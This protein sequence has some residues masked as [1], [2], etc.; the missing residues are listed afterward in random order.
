MTRRRAAQA[1][2]NASSPGRGRPQP[3][4]NVQALRQ[5]AGQ[6]RRRDEVPLQVAKPKRKSS[7]SIIAA[8]GRPTPRARRPRPSVE[9]GRDGADQGRRPAARSG[10]RA[11][12]WRTGRSRPSGLV[13]PT[14]TTGRRPARRRA[15]APGG[16]GGGV[17]WPRGG[18]VPGGGDDGDAEPAQRPQRRPHHRV[19]L[20]RRRSWQQPSDSDTTSTMSSGAA[21]RSARGPAGLTARSG[22]AGGRTRRPPRRAVPPDGEDAASGQRWWTRPG[23]EPRRRATMSSDP[24]SFPLTTPR[25]STSATPPRSARSAAGAGRVP[26]DHAV[27]PGWMPVPVSSTATTGRRAPSSSSPG[28]RGGRGRARPPGTAAGAGPRV[29]RGGRPPL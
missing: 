23:D 19:E 29:L 17:A 11:R 26:L 18:V 13:A 5:V 3:L 10:P 6:D 16:E 20:R 25:R 21:L 27:Q 24:A 7:G 2:A 8:A 4:R 1:T 9:A 15:C 12:R 28:R 14:V 22:R